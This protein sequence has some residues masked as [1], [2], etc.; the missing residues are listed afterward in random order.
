MSYWLEDASGKWLGDFASVAGI[1]ELR[2][3]GPNLDKFLFTGEASK[4][5]ATEVIKDIIG[6]PKAGYIADLLQADGIKFP[7]IITD[8]M[9]PSINE[10]LVEHHHPGGKDHDQD[11]HGNWAKGQKKFKFAGDDEGDGGEPPKKKKKGAFSRALEKVKPGEIEEED[12][13]WHG[14]VTTTSIFQ[15]VE[16]RTFEANTYMGRDDEDGGY[17]VLRR[18]H[19]PGKIGDWQGGVSDRYRRI[20]SEKFN[21]LKDILDENYL[22][23]NIGEFQ[24]NDEK[25]RF[26]RTG[27]GDAKA[28]FSHI[29]AEFVNH[30]TYNSSYNDMGIM[31]FSGEGK[32]RQKLYRFLA[33]RVNNILPNWKGYQVDDEHFVI[34]DSDFDAGDGVK[35]G[36]KVQRLFQDFTDTREKARRSAKTPGI[37]YLEDNPR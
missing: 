11:E 3:I 13:G 36:G 8:G 33:D 24:F 2:D 25:R 4:P 35:I 20:L 30:L 26:A 31:T 15:P 6:H 23:N 16:G 32:S 12:R 17:V 27:K 37:E 1:V 7:V 5:L 14:M 18:V 28:V 21:G 19:L 10:D 22:G 9:G 29:A 34:I